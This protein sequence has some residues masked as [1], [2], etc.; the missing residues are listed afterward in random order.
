[1]NAKQLASLVLRVVV[2]FLAVAVLAVGVVATLAPR[3]FYDRV[4]G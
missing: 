2:W 1:M 3:I 4:R